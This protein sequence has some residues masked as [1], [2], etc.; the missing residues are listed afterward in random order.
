MLSVRAMLSC[1]RVHNGNT[2]ESSC[3][4]CVPIYDHLN[5]VNPVHRKIRLNE[6][7]STESPSSITSFAFTS[8][9]SAAVGSMILMCVDLAW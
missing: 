8:P 2:D 9:V 6:A 3:I 1:E 4:Q 7:T 5:V